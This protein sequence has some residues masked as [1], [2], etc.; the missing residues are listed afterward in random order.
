MPHFIHFMSV[1]S[2]VFNTELIRLVNENMCGEEHLFIMQGKVTYEK[3]SQCYKNIAYEPY[4][5]LSTV[6]KYDT[7]DTIL[8]L[9]SL[10]LNTVELS[11]LKKK[12]ARRIVW[13][14]WGHDLYAVQSK[15]SLSARLR[16]WR[17]DRRISCFRAIVA[18]FKHDAH[19]IRRRFGKQV[20]IYN[21]L[22]GSGYFR[23]D[24]DR[25]VCSQ[26]Q[27]TDMRTNIMIGHSAYPF[28]QH[29]KQLERLASYKDENIIITLFLSYG[30][31]E[32]ADK[33]IEYASTMFEKEK[34]NVIRD[35]VTWDR[36]IEILCT[37][38]IAIFDFDHQAAFGNLILLSYL[39][40]KL[41]LSQSGVMY[42]AF[43]AEHVA[44]YDCAE[45][46]KVTYEKFKTQTQSNIDV[47]YT[48]SLLNKKNIITQWKGLFQS[49]R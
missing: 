43:Q 23:E 27:R 21:A 8:I 35:F 11:H 6:C 31:E 14:V 7:G 45:I 25:I 16:N 32:Y 33:V 49:V 44:V 38:D 30:D 1:D 15:H 3:L 5:Q 12:M 4:F 47:S 2:P 42:Q 13:C 19:E 10:F 41:Y 36:Y 24:I 20:P 37:V 29:K 22:Y 40:K 26:K 17:A 46:G 48:E 18:G 34:L 9:H 28:L 39:R